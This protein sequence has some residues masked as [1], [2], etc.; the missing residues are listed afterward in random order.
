M[1]EGLFAFVDVF[2]F[3]REDVF[4]QYDVKPNVVPSIAIFGLD[5]VAPCTLIVGFQ[6]I[7]DFP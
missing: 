7:G 3:G 6:H 4:E 1:D 2:L 5:V